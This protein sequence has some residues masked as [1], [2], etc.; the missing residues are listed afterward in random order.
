[1][2]DLGKWVMVKI[3]YYHKKIYNNKKYIINN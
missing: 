3:Y 1:M 2:I